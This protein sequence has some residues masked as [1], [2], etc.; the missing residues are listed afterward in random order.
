ME[1]LP[2]RVLGDEVEQQ[3]ANI[4]MATEGEL[5]VDETF[6]RREAELVEARDGVAGEPVLA[7]LAEWAS[8]A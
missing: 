2:Q 7:Q 5:R 4:V 6:Q 1:A 3:A 8:A